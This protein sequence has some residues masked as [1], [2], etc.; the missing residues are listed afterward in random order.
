VSSAASTP[1]LVLANLPTPIVHF[2]ALDALV[3]SEVW[4]KRDDATAGAEAGNKIRKLQYLLAEAR[5]RRSRVV[6][7]C[8]GLQS[9]HARATAV[10]ARGLGIRPVLFLRTDRAPELPYQGNLLLCHLLGAEIHFIDAAQYANRDALMAEFA[11]RCGQRGES[12]YVIPE[13][14]S[15]GLG[16][17]GYLDAMAEVRM[18]LDARREAYPSTFAAV[19]HAC[20]SGG[21]AAGCVLGAGHHA[22]ADEV[23]AMAVCDDRSYF[24]QRIAAIIAETARYL[25]RP[26]RNAQLRV[27]DAY[28]GPAYGEASPEQLDF[29]AAVARA[30][31]LLLDPVYS[32]KALY[33]LAQ[34][35][36]KPQRVLF[37]HTG[38]LPGLLAQAANFSAAHTAS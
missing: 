21:T 34:L 26:L 20:G 9:N 22:I 4:V 23:I 7:T 38:G 5:A 29:I 32:G 12:A 1:R 18:Q 15:N 3:G 24:E 8:G 14:G 36:Q 17:L 13:G 37:L 25:P 31:G 27:V 6:I 10:A 19:V 11:E 2:D 16:A 28:K 33:G 35:A 30:S